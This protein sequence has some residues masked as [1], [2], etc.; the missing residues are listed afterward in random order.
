MKSLF[1]KPEKE[2]QYSTPVDSGQTVQNRQTDN[3]TTTEKF[4]QY[5]DQ[6]FKDANLPGPDYFEL[7]IK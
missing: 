1:R 7:P 6:L 3:G 5:F 4:K 2:K